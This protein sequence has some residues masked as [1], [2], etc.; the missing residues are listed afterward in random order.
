MLCYIKEFNKKFV[1][2]LAID[3]KSAAEIMVTQDILYVYMLL[4]SIGLSVEL[5]MLVNMDSKGAVD[6]ANKWTVRGELIMCM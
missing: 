3:A 2:L 5:P 4:Q 1:T 6:L